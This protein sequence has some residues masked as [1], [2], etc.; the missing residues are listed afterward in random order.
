MSIQ[1]ERTRAVI[2]LTKERDELAR[3]A[4]QLELSLRMAAFTDP[5]ETRKR[6]DRLAVVRQE[7]EAVQ[8]ELDE[9]AWALETD[10]PE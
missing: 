1:R 3:T 7:L 8:D 9:V 2:R 5:T 10:A 4:N 6:R